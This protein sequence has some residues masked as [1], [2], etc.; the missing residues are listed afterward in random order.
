[1]NGA[2]GSIFSNKPYIHI[3]G[4]VIRCALFK[5]NEMDELLNQTI[6]TGLVKI[7]NWTRNENKTDWIIS[8]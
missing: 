4:A 8:K 7:W 1:L 3:P 5:G 6:V 2:G